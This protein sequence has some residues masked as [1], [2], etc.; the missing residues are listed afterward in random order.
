MGFRL[1]GSDFNGNKIAAFA[2]LDKLRQ[3][4]SNINDI[5]MYKV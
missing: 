4:M 1:V 2:S 5:A 3:L